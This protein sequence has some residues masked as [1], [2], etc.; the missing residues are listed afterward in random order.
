MHN[1]EFEKPICTIDAVLIRIE[2]ESLEVGLIKRPEDARV[3]GGIY[4]TEKEQLMH[5]RN[6]IMSNE[7]DFLKALNCKGFKETYGG[8]LHGDKNKRLPNKELQAAA[9]KQPYIAN[10]SFYFFTKMKPAVISGNKL[11]EKVL[12]AYKDGQPMRDFLATA[13]G[14]QN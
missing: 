5:I 1:I 2:N 8:L 6:H 11:M 7:K 3:Y 13:A 12:N 10:K 9:E 4:M 14:K